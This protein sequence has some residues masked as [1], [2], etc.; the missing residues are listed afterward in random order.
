MRGAKRKGVRYFG[1]VLPRLGDPRDARP[2][3]AGLPGPHL[4]RR[5][6][7]AGRPGRPALPARLHR[8]VLGALRRPG[9]RRGAPRRSST[10]S[11]TSWPARPRRFVR[12]LER[13]MQA[14][15]AELRTTSGRPGCATTS[16]RCERAMEKQAVVLGDGT[17]AD[18]VALR[19]GRARGR[20]PGLPRPRRPGP[21]PAR[22][23]RRQ[24]RGRHHRP[25]WSS[26]SS[27]RCTASE[28]RRRASRARCSCRRCPTDAD[29]DPGA[30]LASC[31]AP[32]STCGCRSAATSGR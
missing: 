10:T 16:A 21:R 20:G 19:R 6:L 30:W 25:T 23:G 28:R 32:G 14:A 11:A 8:Q 2:A 13:E 18:V 4:Q 9:Q 1:P 31:A 22:L 17:D 15:A 3:A 27:S 24:G 7:Q 29:G 12:R 26:S 5:R